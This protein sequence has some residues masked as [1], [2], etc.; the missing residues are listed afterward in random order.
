MA[1]NLVE[2]GSDKAIGMNI[3]WQ[4]TDRIFDDY[5]FIGVG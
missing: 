4:K 2:S 3:L 1:K 5:A